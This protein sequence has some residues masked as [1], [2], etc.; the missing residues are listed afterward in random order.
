MNLAIRTYVLL[1]VLPTLLVDRLRREERGQTAAEYLGVI[2]VIA[3]LVA[4]LISTDIGTALRT[5]IVNAI[6]TVFQ[7]GGGAAP[8]G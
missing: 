2:L 1:Q 7:K 6:N 8:G 4:V 3:A 5:N